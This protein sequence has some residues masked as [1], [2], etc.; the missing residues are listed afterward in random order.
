ALLQYFKPEN[1]ALVLSALKMAG[2]YDLIGN[3]KNCLA[4]G[5]KTIKNQKTK[6]T[7]RNVHKKKKSR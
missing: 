4:Q 3:G 5:D 6:K 7:I 2:R 1:K